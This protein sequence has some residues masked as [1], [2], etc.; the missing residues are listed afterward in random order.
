MNQSALNQLIGSQI[1]ALE[2]TAEALKT[3]VMVQGVVPKETGE[4]ERS[5]FIDSSSLKQGLVKLAYDTPYARRL[6][7]HPELSFR[8][9]KNPNARGK[10]LEKWISGDRKE[11]AK[12]TYR[13]LFKQLSGG[14]IR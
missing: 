13:K 11:F 7:F 14:V 2:M 9:D 4:L 8:T 10:W 6:Y 12:N 5:A 3:D 1:Q